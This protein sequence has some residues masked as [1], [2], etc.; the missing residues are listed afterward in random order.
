M[1]AVTRFRHGKMLELSPNGEEQGDVDF[2]FF[3]RLFFVGKNKRSGGSQ[4]VIACARYLG[5]VRDDGGQWEDNWLS[6]EMAGRVNCWA[7]LFFS[8]VQ[9]SWIKTFN[10]FNNHK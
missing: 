4:T 2:F 6:S 1:L 9:R 8:E 3:G 5:L 10:L 7:P